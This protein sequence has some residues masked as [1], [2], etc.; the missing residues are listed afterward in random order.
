MAYE[1]IQA[2]K[3]ISFP[4]TRPQKR[5]DEEVPRGGFQF[6]H[7]LADDALANDDSS[8]GHEKFPVSLMSAEAILILAQAQEEEF[9]LHHPSLTGPL[10]E[11]I[12]NHAAEVVPVDEDQLSFEFIG[13]GHGDVVDGEV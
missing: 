12:Y 13:D 9:A 5:D 10:P 6:A 1:A 4:Q 2:P 3:S 11:M 7:W 8:G